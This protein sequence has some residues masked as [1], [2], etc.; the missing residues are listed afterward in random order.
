MQTKNKPF[1]LKLFAIMV[2]TEFILLFAVLLIQG[3][4]ISKESSNIVYKSNIEKLDIIKDYAEMLLGDIE[5]IAFNAVFDD[6]ISVV[7]GIKSSDSINVNKTFELYSLIDFLKKRVVVDSR[8]DSVYLYHY[9]SDIIVTSNTGGRFSCVAYFLTLENF[10]P[11]NLHICLIDKP[12]FFNF[13]IYL[14]FLSCGS[15]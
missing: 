1:Y 4:I 3:L 11:V 15:S 10:S 13:S 8:I 12:L 5:T 9:N 6:N 7:D 2:V 14:S